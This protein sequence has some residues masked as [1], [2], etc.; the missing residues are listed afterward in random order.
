MKMLKMKQIM[1]NWKIYL[2]YDRLGL[3]KKKEQQT[4]KQASN[5]CMK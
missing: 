3:R 4:E 1:Q 5:I 2:Y